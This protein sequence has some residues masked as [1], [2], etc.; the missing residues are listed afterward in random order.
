MD[1][2]TITYAACSAGSREGALIAVGFAWAS[3]SATASAT[4][5]VELATAPMP[6]AKRKL[7]KPESCSSSRCVL[8]G[9]SERNVAPGVSNSYEYCM[10][11]RIQNR[12]RYHILCNDSPY[13]YTCNGREFI[14]SFRVPT[15][16]ENK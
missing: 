1:T 3:A 9:S 12:A 6:R 4:A 8:R 5:S 11:Q 10:V 2:R 15:P 13:H 14:V 16:V 7:D